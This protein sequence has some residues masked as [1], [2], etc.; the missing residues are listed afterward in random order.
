MLKLQTDKSF[1]ELKRLPRWPRNEYVN[2]A[3][4]A[5]LR[6]TVRT[7]TETYVSVVKTF[8]QMVATLIGVISKTL[9]V[10]K[11][12][13]V[14][15]SVASYLAFMYLKES[16]GVE[17]AL[18]CGILASSPNDKCF[19]NV[20]AELVLN[21]GQQQ[22][23]AQ[24]FCIMAPKPILEAFQKHLN[25][26]D[27]MKEICDRLYTYK[28]A[29][30]PQDF[31][32]VMP[33][34][35][36]RKWFELMTDRI[37]KKLVL[38]RMLA[39]NILER[40]TRGNLYLRDGLQL[41][42]DSKLATSAA[43]AAMGLS[44]DF[45][46]DVR[47]LDVQREIGRGTTG[48]TYL[49]RWRGTRCAVKVVQVQKEGPEASLLMKDFT[50][51]VEVLTKARHPNICQFL[52]AAIDPPTYCVVLEYMD[53][54]SLYDILRTKKELNFFDIA[55]NVA[56]GME[57]LHG[58]CNMMHRDMKSPN[59]LLDEYG[60]VKIADFGLTCLDNA[61]EKTA[62]IGTYRWMAPEVICHEP[63][64]LMAD[65]YSYGMVLFE[66]YTR[67]LPFSGLSPMKVAMSV[68][69]KGT[70]PELP[71]DTPA[72][73]RALITACWAQKPHTRP[74]FRDILATLERVQ[75]NLTEAE[76]A[77]LTTRGLLSSKNSKNSPDANFGK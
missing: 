52:G 59:L 64:G 47:E 29:G 35:T 32:K 28:M 53:H 51:E 42:D 31:H 61:G 70:R 39:N 74:P 17:R 56:C 18:V 71:A 67:E 26:T 2:E 8:S 58:H 76:R 27:E 50:R 22:A 25:G 65:V 15:Q 63:Y 11:G 12:H 23:Y 20:Y 13:S 36:S 9:D 75:S 1:D 14:G 54:G 57:Y 69:T 60:R 45:Q 21:L 30:R 16:I 19:P 55:K 5:A 68:A 37:D 34:L 49:A 6:E 33:D 3:K 72:G 41:L 73:L 24:A 66:L 38:E 46:I 40:G 44:K 10:L 7:S 43:Y 62:E 77:T 4:I 48:S